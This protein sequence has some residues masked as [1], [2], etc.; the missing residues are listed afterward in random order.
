MNINFSSYNQYA[1]YK[2]SGLFKSQAFLL[3]LNRIVYVCSFICLYCVFMFLIT[4]TLR[5][6]KMHSYHTKPSSR[7]T[8]KN[9]KNL[10]IYVYIVHFHSENKAR[11]RKSL[12]PIVTE[13]K[14]IIYAWL[15][16]I[17]VL[18]ISIIQVSDNAE[19]VWIHEMVIMQILLYLMLNFFTFLYLFKVPLLWYG[20]I[21]VQM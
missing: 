4:L 6:L 3:V 18:L 12:P 13:N 19:N 9:L 5:S 20:A 10:H 7:K 16:W 1:A 8:W 14:I 15:S 2:G 11:K 17:I 21:H